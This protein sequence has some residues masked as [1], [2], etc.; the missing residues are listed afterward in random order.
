MAKGLR[1]RALRELEA[2]GPSGAVGSGCMHLR[3]AR[4]PET[5]IDALPQVDRQ[6]WA[7]GPADGEVAASI[8]KRDL[9][10]GRCHPIRQQEKMLLLFPCRPAHDP[11]NSRAKVNERAEQPPVVPWRSLEGA[12]PAQSR[13]R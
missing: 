9:Q 11:Y 4:S 1:V 3:P 6:S 2:E 12:R 7:R 10:G 13:S 8:V 5:Q